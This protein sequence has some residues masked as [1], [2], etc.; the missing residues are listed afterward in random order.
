MHS[1]TL[2]WAIVIGATVVSGA[3]GEAPPPSIPSR[4]DTQA[5]R[6][7]WKIGAVNRTRVEVWNWFDA[8]V[9]APGRGRE[10]DY[11]FAG[12]LTKVSATRK[13]KK[14]DSLVE[15]AVPALIGLP[16]DAIAP[17][18]AGQLGLGS[19]YRA[20]NRGQELA[21]VVRQA[22]AVFRELA[23]PHLVLKVGRFE[24][25]DGAEAF[26]KDATLDSLKRERIAQRLIGPFGFSHIGRSFDGIHANHDRRDIVWTAAAVRPTAGVFDLDANQELEDIDVGYLAWTRR[27][28]TGRPDLRLFALAYDDERRVIKVDN[29]PSRARAADRG[30][31]SVVTFGGHLLH[32]IGKVDLLGWGAV[33][34]GS[35]GALDHDAWAA[36]A[37]VGYRP[38]GAWKPWIRA[39][40]DAASGDRDPADAMHGTF[41]QVLP[42]PRI[43]AR[44]PFF[45]LMNLR[46]TFGQ[47]LLKPT[48]RLDLRIDYH[49]LELDR[50]TDLWYL[51]GGAFQDATFGFVGRPAGG[52]GARGLAQLL[53]AS[54]GYRLSA[55]TS[56][57]LYGATVDG[58]R[59][60]RTTFPGTRSAFAYFELEHRF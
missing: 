43:Y 41:F 33:Q 47:V 52:G 51:G 9:P 32:T 3:A 53:D 39:G 38:G 29:R 14:R 6:A 20:A 16:R 4:S 22:H 59:V 56:A 58:G 23:G 49:D 5:S 34:G 36:A 25:A 26:T 12:S 57:T 21:L 54:V 44:F 50:A 19:T 8:G 42:T 48:G 35:W 1:R 10:D 45:N 15:V 60:V 40:Y 55:R 2:A 24:L 13:G 11:T 28:G 37:E 18:A 30:D 17:G 27:G 7:P 46:D 31:V